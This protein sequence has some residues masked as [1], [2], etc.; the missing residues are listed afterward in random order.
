MNKKI[1]QIKKDGWSAQVKKQRV[2]DGH[3]SLWNY[4]THIRKTNSYKAEI[5]QIR[6]NYKI[7]QENIEQPC[8]ANQEKNTIK[9]YENKKTGDIERIICG[10]RLYPNEWEL[11]Y[12]SLKDDLEKRIESLC[13]QH[14]LFFI[15]FREIILL[16]LFYNKIIIPPDL[17]SYNLCSVRDLTEEK[18]KGHITENDVYTNLNFETSDDIFFPIAIKLSPYASKRNILNYIESIYMTE[19]KPLQDKYKNIN[20]KEGKNIK[21]GKIRSR[22]QIKQTR[23]NFIYQNKHLPLK[24]IGNLVYD[25]FDEL[26]DDGHIGKVISLE[27]KERK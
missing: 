6:Q 9:Y 16:D 4:F 25:K 3:I 22:N 27:R 20:I 2:T 5:K 15:E 18:M 7:S 1:H 23:N 12:M 11:K 24:K 21:I 10:Y 13:V 26:L 17:N 14:S 8:K 19:I